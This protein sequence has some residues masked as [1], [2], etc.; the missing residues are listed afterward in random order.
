MGRAH[1]KDHFPRFRARRQVSDG[2]DLR[3]VLSFLKVEEV[4]MW[5]SSSSPP[6]TV[7]LHKNIFESPRAHAN[8][9][10]GAKGGGLNMWR[11]FRRTS[12]IVLARVCGAEST[13]TLSVSVS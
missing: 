8:A 6:Q 2:R 12:C 13:R 11:R 4:C 1:N 9:M 10:H 7:T 3:S 5:N